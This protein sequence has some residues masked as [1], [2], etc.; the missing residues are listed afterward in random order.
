[1][2]RLDGDWA[3]SYEL[4]NDLIFCD[5]SKKQSGKR[6]PNYAD[7]PIYYLNTADFRLSDVDYEYNP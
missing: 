3:S 4:H 1:M 2:C 5:C 7:N 6:G